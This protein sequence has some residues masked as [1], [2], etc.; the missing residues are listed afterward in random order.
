MNWRPFYL[1]LD[2]LTVHRANTVKGLYERYGITAIYNVTASPEYNCIE[3]VFA[4]V[5]AQYARARLNALANNSDFD[6]DAEA[7][8]AF[9]IVTTDLVDNCFKRSYYLLNND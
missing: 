6:L 7:R 4:H 5:K 9:N 2:K 3:T 8:D 1:F